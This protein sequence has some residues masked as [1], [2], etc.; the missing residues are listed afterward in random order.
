M[1]TPETTAA[2]VAAAESAAPSVTPA[3]APPG[4]QGAR[5]CRCTKRDGGGQDHDPARDGFLLHTGR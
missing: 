1:S 5:A 3:T 4:G 2:H